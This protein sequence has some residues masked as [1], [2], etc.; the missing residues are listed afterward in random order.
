M[1]RAV[2]AQGLSV[3]GTADSVTSLD[4]VIHDFYAW[5]GDILG[6]LDR[7]VSADPDFSLGHTAK[8][9]ILMLG[10][11]RGDH[12]A[13]T[14]AVATAS[15]CIGGSTPRE[16]GH[17]AIAQ[18]LAAGEMRGAARRCEAILI[19][20]PVDALALRYA[21]DLHY[22]LG[23][24]AGIR[25]TVARVLPQWREDDPLFGFVLGRYAF[26]LEETGALGEAERWGRRALA[27]N[28]QDVW[29]THAIAHVFE[30][31]GRSEEGRQ[32]LETTRAHWSV[33]KW[34]A[35]HNGWHLAL[36]LIELGRGEE[37]LSGYDTF[38][39]PR[40]KDN[41]I[42][43]LIDASSLLWRLSLAG[44]EVGDR[45]AE[46]ARV[47]A[48]RIGEHVLAFND[49][50]M[51]LALIGAG[52]EPATRQLHDS[53][54]RYLASGHGDNRS[55]TAA[56]GKTLVDAMAAYGQGEWRRTIALLLPIRDQVIRIG[57]SHAQRDVVDQ[58][59]VAA[60]L[61]AEDWPLA[62]SLLTERIARTPT[63]PDWS[64]YRRALA[65]LGDTGAWAHARR[66]FVDE[67]P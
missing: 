33:G 36:F 39:A 59:L 28:R 53:I 14:D 35:V 63:G 42:L 47:A 48:Q 18:S 12:T 65:G 57:G 19:D 34:L 10:G 49:L 29:A 2:D 54:D 26:G 46:V 3:T 52:D 23:D 4:R 40:L 56:V 24:S 55:T 9:I 41:F 11:L 60:A 62:R 1:K 7:A 22:Y 64:L 45:W 61:R 27:I 44:I 38:V 15:R 31:N 16:A 13:V 20:H 58:T 25:D 50:H 67:R 43:D 8:A 5:T 21:T 32:F 66:L 6:D 30:T 17:L 37:V 51:A